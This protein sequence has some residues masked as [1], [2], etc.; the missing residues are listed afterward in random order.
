MRKLFLLAATS[1]MLGSSVNAQTTM[2]PMP[3]PQQPGTA[4]PAP[5]QPPSVQVAPIAPSTLP[6]NDPGAPLAGANS[7]TEGQARS[8]IEQLGYT[9][10]TGLAKDANGVWRGKA[11][12][13]GT[14]H[15]VSVDFRGNIVVGQK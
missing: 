6:K 14:T 7:F 1:A 4:A 12:K 8:R 9:N 2:T 5:A 13:D 10:V 15:D 3:T 11:S